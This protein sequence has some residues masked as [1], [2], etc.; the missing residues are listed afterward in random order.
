MYRVTFLKHIRV[1]PDGPSLDDIW[2]ELEAELP[3]APMPWVAYTLGDN[4]ISPQSIGFDIDKDRF[5]LLDR[6]ETEYVDAVRNDAVNRRSLDAIVEDYTER[7]W[8]L[9]GCR[10][11]DEGEED[12]D[13]CPA[14]TD[15]AE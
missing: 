9:I 6:D 15:G 3:F 13:E 7:G 12:G 5:Y 8:H 2:L 14:T 4:E 10:I 1:R 11:P